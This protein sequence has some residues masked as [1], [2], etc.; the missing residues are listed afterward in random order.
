M[1]CLM[2]NIQATSA[3]LDDAALRVEA[4]ARLRALRVG[5]RLTQEELARRAGVTRFAII[6]LEAGNPARLDTFLEVVRVLGRLDALLSALAT[7]PDG[8]SPMSRVLGRDG[9][10]P[11]A[12]PQRVR[13]RGPR[14]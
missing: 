1:L 12:Q 14:R 10:K 7:D 6:S 9:G 13:H 3:L 2:D 11:R 8:P 5:A 4:G